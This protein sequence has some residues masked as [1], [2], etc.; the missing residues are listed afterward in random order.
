M[1][2]SVLPGSSLAI[3]AHR[4]PYLV[5]LIVLPFMG[6]NYSPILFLAPALF[7]DIWIQVVV[8]SF[9]ALLSN[10]SRQ[11]FGY[12]APVFRTVLFYQF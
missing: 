4:L 11:L 5:L 10:S 3:M 12:K 8:P 2:L 1:E 7:D 9:P 6:L